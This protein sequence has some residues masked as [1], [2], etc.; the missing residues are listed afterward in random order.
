MTRDHQSAFRRAVRQAQLGD[1]RGTWIEKLHPDI[2][3]QT[4]PPVLVLT[5]SNKPL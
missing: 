4:N 1:Y 2:Q 5:V 3:P